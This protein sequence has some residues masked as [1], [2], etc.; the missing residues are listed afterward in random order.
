M[1]KRRRSVSCDYPTQ[2]GDLTLS[3]KGYLYSGWDY[4]I[5]LPEITR[6]E[7]V[8][9]WLLH[10]GCKIDIDPRDLHLAFLHIFGTQ[11][12]D[13]PRPKSVEDYLA[14]AFPVAK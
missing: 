9:F 13:E 11:A 7:H 3:R 4:C 2:F 8:A 5:P 14:K 12:L 10:A 1:I 6:W